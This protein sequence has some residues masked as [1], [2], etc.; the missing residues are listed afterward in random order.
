MNIKDKDTLHECTSC[1]MCAAVCPQEAIDIQ[2]NKDGFY[3]PVVKEDKCVDCGL[4]KKIC[5]KFSDIPQYDINKKEMSIHYAASVKDHEILKHTTSGGIAD[6]LCQNLIAEG[7]TCV[8]V[9]YDYEENRAVGKI[10]SGYEEAKAFRG[11]KYI[12][13]YSYPTFKKLLSLDKYGKYA[14]FGTPCQIFALDNYLKLKRLRENFLLIDIYCHGCPSLNVWK[15]YI[16]DIQQKTGFKTFDEL[17]FRS[18]VRGWG[19]FYVVVVVGGKPVYVSPKINDKFYSLFFSDAI[20]NN[21][22]YDC[23]L[24]ST[25]EHCDIRL[26]DFWGKCYDMNN[27][28]V[29]LVSLPSSKGIKI[30]SDLKSKLWCREH[31]PED[32]LPY[33]SWGR[34]YRINLTL[35]HKLLAMLFDENVSLKQVV[36]V[37]WQSMSF[38]EKNKQIAKNVVLL[39]PATII[40]A[41]KRIFH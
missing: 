4:C 24:R 2:L 40:S 19:N 30:F 8:G 18:K 11:S 23:Q 38:K 31:C 20:L 12:Q 39:M 27:Q 16:R 26:G 36:T 9:E 21:A 34:S 17:N 14:V 10:A 37:Y 25:L 15:K 7:Y 29:S 13:S 6:V 41:I 22:C 5:Y 1:Q 32:F 33:Q 3:R 28:G 35:R